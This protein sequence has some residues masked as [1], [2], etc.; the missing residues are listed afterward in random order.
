MKPYHI[1]HIKE[2]GEKYP[3]FPN[4]R[5]R[6]K[7][8]FSEWIIKNYTGKDSPAGDLAGDVKTGRKIHPGTF[9]R[10]ETFEEWMAYL[11]SCRASSAAVTTFRSMW[12]TYSRQEKKN[13]T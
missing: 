8:K 11:G 10:E 2:Y 1:T 9:P 7:M 6:R 13:G 4:Y 5:E 12:A 3:P